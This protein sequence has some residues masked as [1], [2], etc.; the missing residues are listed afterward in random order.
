[1]NPTQRH[2]EAF[3]FGKN[4]RRPEND[5]EVIRF[6]FEDDLK[7]VDMLYHTKYILPMTA[8]SRLLALLSATALVT[9]ELAQ[10]QEAPA[11]RAQT[12]AAPA[13]RTLTP[14]P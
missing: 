9:P 14:A 7:M 2:F 12:P 8:A 6:F 11:T 1:M 3:P 4:P 13:S 10:A 5:A